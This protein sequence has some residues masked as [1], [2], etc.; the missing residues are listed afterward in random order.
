MLP[1]WFGFCAYDSD[2]VQLSAYRIW[3]ISLSA[4]WGKLLTQFPGAEVAHA[5]DLKGT[6]H[7][8]TIPPGAGIGDIEADGSWI[9]PN[10]PPRD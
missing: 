7:G 3:D 1:N 5:Q 8:N 10:W 9:I 6:Q 2:G 4:A